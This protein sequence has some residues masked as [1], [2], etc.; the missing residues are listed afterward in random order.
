MEISATDLDTPTKAAPAQPADAARSHRWHRPPD[1]GRPDAGD[2][3]PPGKRRWKRPL[4]GVV[5]V[6]LLVVG[7]SYVH[8]LTAPGTD[9]MGVRS[10]E[11][12]RGH[13]GGGIVSTV[14]RWWYSHHQPR[15]GGPPPAV[16]VHPA[17][18]ASGPTPAPTTRAASSTS[19]QHLPAPST[20]PPLASPALPREGVWRPA[21]RLVHG[22]P[23][24]Y[25]TALR[26]DPV[27][28]SLATGVAWMDPTLLKPVLFAGIQ[29]PGG[30]WAHEAPVP[31]AERPS[32]VAAFNSGFRL[33]ESRGGYYSEGRTARPLLPGA[34]SLVIDAAGR[35]TVGMWGR[36][37]QMSP[38]V[39]SV[40]Q[41]LALIVDGG[42]P[43][44]GLDQNLR[45]QWGAT[46]GNRIFVWRS[47]VGV[48][49]NGALVYAAG[50]GLSVATLARVLT[51]AG[52]VR[53]MELDINS[54][55]TR[56]FSYDAADPANPAAVAGTK[57]VPDMRASP[58]LYLEAETRDFVALFA[59]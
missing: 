43:V 18:T 5:A 24:V 58:A 22:V 25:T 21:G 42:A 27:H 17:P 23:A 37:I 44:A 16:L 13:G 15:K 2:A 45:G 46:V 35:P 9:G 34:A 4:I 53:A 33:G 56:F 49:R 19:V 26:P 3:P 36:D 55:W 59:R 29:L 48:T 7:W 30:S 12:L 47:G 51:A 14:E 11:W 38:S 41:N 52:A 31:M 20:I 50:N 6:V 28:T 54:E 40:R 8:A 57:L 1:A 39:V 32:L 10:V